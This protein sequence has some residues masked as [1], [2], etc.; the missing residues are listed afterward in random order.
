MTEITEA[1]EAATIRCT[2]PN[3]HE[4]FGGFP[5]LDPDCP[6]HGDD[7]VPRTKESPHGRNLERLRK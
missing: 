5:L 6:E 7:S 3:A 2:C 4:K 1:D